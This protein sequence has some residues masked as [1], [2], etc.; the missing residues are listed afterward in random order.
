MSHDFEN[1]DEGALTMCGLDEYDPVDAFENQAAGSSTT[2][3]SKAAE[4]LD[5]L[6]N[7]DFMTAI[8]GSTFDAANP[9]VCKNRAIRE[10]VVGSHF[11][12]LAIQ[13]TRI[14]TGM[15]CRAYINLMTL[16]ATARKKNWRS[17]YSLSW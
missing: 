4:A 7:D 2:S 5:T 8:F 10:M 1:A 17:R 14:K 16:V 6:S 12:G 9:L 11:D 15:P 3:C 13:V